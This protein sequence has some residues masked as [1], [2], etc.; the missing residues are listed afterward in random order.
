M[1]SR[2]HQLGYSKHLSGKLS[3]LTENST[4][5][6]VRRVY[7]DWARE[8]DKVK[9][10]FWGWTGQ[11]VEWRGQGILNLPPPIPFTPASR[12]FLQ[13]FLPAISSPASHPFSLS[14]APLHYI[15]SI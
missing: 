12:P 10:L 7:D 4:E 3:N 1:A 11:Y 6:D 8:Y 13:W 9:N 5:D 2:D 15:E 14:P